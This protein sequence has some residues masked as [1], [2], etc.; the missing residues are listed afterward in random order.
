MTKRRKRKAKGEAAEPVDDAVLRVVTSVLKVPEGLQAE[1]GV[2]DHMSTVVLVVAAV[3]LGF[4]GFIAWL[5][6]EGP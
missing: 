4:I 2:G 6:H 1:K 5:I 3:A